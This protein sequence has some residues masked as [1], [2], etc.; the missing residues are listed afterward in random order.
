[1]DPVQRRAF[2]AFVAD[3]E[4]RLRRALIATYGFEL[5]R[6]ATAN[7]LGW[8]WEHWNRLDKIA[9]KVAYLYRV[10]KSSI[11]RRKV[12]ITF[13]RSE[14]S[15]SWFEPNLAPALAALTDRQRTAVVL[16]HGYRWT[17]REVADLTGTHIGTVQS[18]L[19]RGLHNLRINLEVSDNA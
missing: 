8:A 11:R 5:G 15:E 7:A 19:D 2:E 4:P 6:E 3:A 17:L 1:M 10:G 13:V 16:I 14:D 18:H 9:N 12:P